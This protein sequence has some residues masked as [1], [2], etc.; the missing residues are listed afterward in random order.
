M[1]SQAS[2]QT[3]YQSARLPEENKAAETAT[4]AAWPAAWIAFFSSR[5]FVLF[6]GSLLTYLVA[7]FGQQIKGESEL[8]ISLCLLL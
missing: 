8:L 5:P 1:K 7:A 2:N 6:I 4:G 3:S